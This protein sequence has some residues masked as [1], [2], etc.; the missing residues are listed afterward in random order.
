MQFSGA[1]RPLY[2]YDS[3]GKKIIRIKGEPPSIGGFDRNT[4]KFDNKFLTMATGDMLYLSSDGFID[5]SSPDRVRF[6]T[7]RF[8]ELL[9]NSATLPAKKQKELAENAMK[10]HMKTENQRDDITLVG[11]KF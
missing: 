11:I 10:S 8:L 1:K 3:S 9:T 7:K 4:K 6:G 2:H 5:Q